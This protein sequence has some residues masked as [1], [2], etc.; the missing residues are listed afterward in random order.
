[1]SS[2]LERQPR[3]TTISF[4]GKPTGEQICYA[5]SYDRVYTGLDEPIIE[6]YL[7]DAENERV[8]PIL[9]VAEKIAAVKSAFSLR[10]KELADVLHV[11]RQT[12]YAWIRGENEPN[13]VTLN[14]L[15]LFVKLAAYWNTHSPLPLSHYQLV[16][17]SQGEKSL[18]AVFCEAGDVESVKIYL[19]SYAKTQNTTNKPQRKFINTKKYSNT[20][21]ELLI[22]TVSLWGD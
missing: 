4:P 15:D 5:L 3:V 8:Q 1:M 14:R 21:I 17:Q 20:E 2:I 19:T 7:N 13:M 6:D 11:E 18:L 16:D 12:I 10:T 22:P 9:S